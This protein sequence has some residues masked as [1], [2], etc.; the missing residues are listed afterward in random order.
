MIEHANQP[1][2]AAWLTTWRALQRYHRYEV[3][4]LDH[5]LGDRAVMIAGYHGRPLAWDLCMLTV[6]LHKRRGWLPHGIAH[7][8]FES[9]GFGR[10]MLD[11]LGMVTGDSPELYAAIERGEHI[12]V[13]PGG[14][15]E[16]ARSFRVRYRVDWGRRTGYLRLAR[17]LGIPIV[18]VGASCVDDFY[19]NLVDGHSWGKRLRIPGRLPAWLAF[20]PT[21]PWPFTPTFPVKVRQVIGAPLDV[22]HANDGADMQKLHLHVQR[23]VQDCI[24]RARRC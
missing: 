8:V 6:E 11:E 22:G 24:D 16:C 13:A 14:T 3:E 20:G 5:L 1:F 18:P 9:N 7:T 15:R 10:R 23:A 19:V 4:G 21:G 2:L 12:L 17:Q